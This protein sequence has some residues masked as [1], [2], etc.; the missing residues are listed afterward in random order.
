[1]RV[2]G[3]MRVC[4]V[5]V[6]KAGAST[7]AVWEL[8]VSAVGPVWLLCAAAFTPAFSPAVLCAAVVVSAA[9]PAAA[10]TPAFVSAAVPAMVVAF[11]VLGTPVLGT[12]PSID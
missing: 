9:L 11:A 6:D 1:M 3:R 8:S 2:G 10:F 12:A 5:S 4:V 7:S